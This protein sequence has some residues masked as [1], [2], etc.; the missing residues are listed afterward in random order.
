[1]QNHGK[2]SNK[3]F[4]LILL[5]I[6]NLILCRTKPEI[7]PTKKDSSSSIVF[8]IRVPVT[9]GSMKILVDKAWLIKFD[10]EK[11]EISELEIL[12]TNFTSKER[13][14]YLNIEPGE[15]GILGVFRHIPA[16]K[17]SI[18]RKIWYLFDKNSLQLTKFRV[19]PFQNLVLGELVLD[20]SQIRFGEDYQMD[21][22]A[23]KICPSFADIQ[24]KDIWNHIVDNIFGGFGG[25]VNEASYY[26]VLTFNVS[27]EK[28]EEISKEARLDLE[29]TEWSKIPITK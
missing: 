16:G 2:K 8:Q 19:E 5:V 20:F 29:K 12:E 3:K 26:K 7:K 1:M 14:Y 4:I 18:R 21:L 23:E 11:K 9:I 6:L 27:P 28:K 10:K 17:Y 13:I 24:K 22:I 15:Y 25:T